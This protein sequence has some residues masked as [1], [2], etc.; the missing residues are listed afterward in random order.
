[1]QPRP[2]LFIP[3]PH[4][5]KLFPWPRSGGVLAAHLPSLSLSQFLFNL[6]EM[7]PLMGLLI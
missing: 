3:S 2:H 5:L 6:Q 7:F 4:Q 1:M